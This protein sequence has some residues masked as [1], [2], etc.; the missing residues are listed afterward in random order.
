[1]MKSQLEARIAD[2][3]WSCL[4][5]GERIRHIE[6]EG[7]LVIPDLLSPE[8]IDKLKADHMAK[9]APS[10]NPSRWDRVH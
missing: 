3:D 6:V 5:L 7:Y 2:T 8:H 9:D 4:T 10:I 1:M